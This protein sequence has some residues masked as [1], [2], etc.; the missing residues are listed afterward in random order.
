MIRRPPNSTR[1][2]T[3]FPYTT[4]CRSLLKNR[5]DGG[6]DTSSL[7]VLIQGIT[8]QHGGRQNGGQ[9]IG[10]ILAGD[11]RCRTMTGFV[12]PLVGRIER[13]RRQ[14]AYRTGQHG[15]FVGKEIPESSKERR[16]GKECDSTCRSRWWP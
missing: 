8:Q 6:F 4:L 12:Q 3:L 16:V 13:S 9:R 10:D 14:H 11:V 7:G 5:L 2:D 1:T 15:G